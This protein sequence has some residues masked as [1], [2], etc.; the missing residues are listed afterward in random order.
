MQYATIKIDGW[1]A[2][3]VIWKDGIYIVQPTIY[4]I[5]RD[6]TSSMEYKELTAHCIDSIITCILV[7]HMD[8]T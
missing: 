1:T 5:S 8:R 6:R 7:L 4:N 2:T 3:A